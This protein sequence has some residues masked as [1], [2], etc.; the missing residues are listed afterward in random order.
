MSDEQGKPPEGDA[1]ERPAAPSAEAAAAREAAEAKADAA[2]AAAGSPEAVGAVQQ[3]A[4]IASTAP[5]AAKKPLTDEE[6]AALKAAALEKAKAAAE[7]KKAAAAA[8]APPAEGA[9]PAAKKPLTEEEKAALKAAAL[10][11]A[12]AAKAAGAAGGAAGGAA[13]AAKPKH[14]E[15]PNK[16]AWEKDPVVP[17]WQDASSDPLAA[18]LKDEFG[19]AIESARSFAGD[20]TFQVRRGAVAEV[21]G[22]LKHR[23]KFTYLVDICGADYPKREPRFDVVYHLYSFEANRRVRLKVVTDEAAPVPTVCGVWRAANWSEREIYDMYGVRFEG[24]P[25]MTRI[26]LWEGFNGYP[27]RKDFPVEGIDTGSAIYPEYYEPAA[28]PVAGTG[29]GWKP[30]KPP[31]P[32]T[33]G[34]PPAGAKTPP[35]GAQASGGETPAS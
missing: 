35:P 9:E 33:P 18:A 7:A 15:D 20:L 4:D 29:T 23:H 13:P 16:P 6:K 8:G 34:T 12:K 27:L 21:A 24:H 14:E 25:D 28:G 22:S 3:P 11:K 17:E 10:E 19:D 2:T 26:L 1:P 5:P 32:P 30:A 31:E